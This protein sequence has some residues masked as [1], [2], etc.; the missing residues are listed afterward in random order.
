MSLPVLLLKPSRESYAADAGNNVVS[1]EL[2]GGPSRMRLDMVGAPYRVNVQWVCDGFRYDYLQAF[3][4]SSIAYGSLPFSLDLRLDYTETL[5]YT[6]R[7]VPGTWKLGSLNGELSLVSAQLEVLPNPDSDQDVVIIE[8][9]TTLGPM[10]P[11]TLDQLEELVNED[12]PAAL[13]G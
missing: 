2:S 3:Y 8:M 10:A 9:F 7:V 11:Y 13:P 6:A 1:I 12:L 4:R 5:T